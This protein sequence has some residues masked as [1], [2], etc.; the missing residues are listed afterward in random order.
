[1]DAAVKEQT[2]EMSE[3]N[4]QRNSIESAVD[5][6][7]GNENNNAV[8]GVTSSGVTSRGE[9]RDMQVYKDTPLSFQFVLGEGGR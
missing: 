8:N 7:R 2:A 9:G 1:M 4:R 5:G 6:R 3:A